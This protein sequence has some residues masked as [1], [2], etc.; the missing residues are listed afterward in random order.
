MKNS[1]TKRVCF[2]ATTPAFVYM[3]SRNYISYLHDRGWDITV[4]TAP[5]QQGFGKR[6]YNQE[7]RSRNAK[8]VYVPMKR[9]PSLLCD[10]YTLL[11]LVWF[12]IWN[13]FDIVHCSHPKT[14]LLGTIAA[15]LAF[16]PNRMITVRGRPYENYSGG[17][18]RRFFIL[19]DRIA[20]GLAR[21]NIVVSTSLK[22][23]MLKDKIGSNK[24]LIVFGHGSSQGCDA[25]FFSPEAVPDESTVKLRMECRLKDSDKIILFSGRVRKDK[26]VVELVKAFDLLSKD[27]PDWHLILIGHE[28]KI[29]DVGKE[30]REL[31]HKQPA[32]HHFD[33]SSDLRS[34]YK[35]AD[36]FVLPTW[37]E[38]FPNVIL[39]ASAM[40]LPVVTTDAVG[41]VDSVVDGETGYIVPVGNVD[42]LMD[43]VKYL[44]ERPQL[45]KTMGQNG[46][47]RVIDDFDPNMI[48]QYIHELYMKTAFPKS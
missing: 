14:M 30:I 33:W 40:T 8:M 2:V 23:A 25:V 27:A 32:I 24:S 5:D 46:R 38:G 41:A 15:F 7:L 20:C 37:R 35:L 34:F 45:R 26:G 12:F 10:C 43:K 17:L 21:K 29:S 48:W 16:A 28:E 47:K 36:I 4:V 18:K 13:R 11:R 31:M 9:E 42:I 39:E 6:D 1:S 44:M 22:N 19:C 3:F